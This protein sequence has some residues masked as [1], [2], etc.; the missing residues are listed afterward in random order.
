MMT[1]SGDTSASYNPDNFCS[2]FLQTPLLI[3][4]W[5]EFP[6]SVF[7]FQSL[8]NL[9]SY[10][11][12]CIKSD[13]FSFLE[14]K[15]IYSGR[16]TL[17]RQNVVHLRGQERPN[18]E[19]K[20]TTLL[21]SASHIYVLCDCLCIQMAWTV[22]TDYSRT[23]NTCSP[24]HFW[25]IREGLNLVVQAPGVTWGSV[26][27]VAKAASCEGLTRV[28]SAFQ[29]FTHPGEGWRPHVVL[30]SRALQRATWVTSRQVEHLQNK[31]FQTSPW[32]HVFCGSA[33][34]VTVSPLP[35]SAGHTPGLMWRE[36]SAPDWGAGGGAHQG[37]PWSLTPTEPLIWLHLMS[38]YPSPAHVPLSL[39]P[40]LIFINVFVISV[41][42]P[43]GLEVTHSVSGLLAAA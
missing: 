18:S 28:G 37:P 43:P 13:F 20:L 9:G 6:W 3:L 40:C 30:T 39:C 8:S 21:T 32:S 22:H 24:T 7:S 36:G 27:A 29:G 26:K 14:W 34:E 31:K 38:V 35:C 17:H 33:W 12:L 16:D 19:S 1:T 10:I 25:G 42:P 5:L 41:S 11:F 4:F 2:A 23:T 15:R